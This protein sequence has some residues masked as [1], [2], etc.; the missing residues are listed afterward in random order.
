[1]AMKC[2]K[3]KLTFFVPFF[4]YVF[5]PRTTTTKIILGPLNFAR[6]QKP[7][8]IVY[9]IFDERDIGL[10]FRQAYIKTLVKMFCSKKNYGKTYLS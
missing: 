2:D 5:T 7:M 6:G 3:K 8:R 4:T 10:E 9:A 1:M